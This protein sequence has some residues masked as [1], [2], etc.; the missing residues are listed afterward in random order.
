MIMRSI[1]LFSYF[2]LMLLM[3]SF[4]AL[5]DAV[6]DD[7]EGLTNQD[8]FLYYWYFYD[9]HKDGGNSTIP[10]VTKDAAGDFIVAPAAGIG[11]TGAGL[12]LPYSLGPIKAG[13][14]SGYNSIG[15]GAML[16]A[17]GKSIDLTAATK[18]TFWLKASAAIGVDFNLVTTDVT[19]YAYWHNV[20]QA[21]TA[22]TQFTVTL[23]STGLGALSQP[24]WGVKATWATSISKV[25]KLQWQL[26]SDNVGTA[27]TGSI[28]LDDIVIAGYTFIPP[29][30]CTAC[31]GNPGSGTGALLSDMETLPYSRNARGYYWFSYCDG[32]GRGVA[33]S[34]FSAIT[35]GATID[36]VDPAK[37]TII[38]GPTWPKGYNG[39]NG[40]DIQFT[41]GKAY[42]KTTGG[43]TIKPFVG[44]G[45]NV[46][47]DLG[48]DLYNAQAD[49]AT[50]IYFDYTLSGSSADMFVRLEVYANLIAVE[51]AVHYI[52]LPSTGAGVWKGATV[53][54]SK[55]VLQDW[56]GVTQVALDAT[57]MKKIQWAV[58]WDAGATG[59]LGIDN[60]HMLGAT[61]ITSDVKYHFSQTRMLNGFTPSISNNM[62]KVAFNKGMSDVSAS[63]VNTKG[64]I[65]AHRVAGNDAIATMNVSGLS[66]GVYMLVV[67][68]NSKTGAFNKTV[69]LTIY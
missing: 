42:T 43:S 54:F 13:T 39:S 33:A 59:E 44:I 5:A 66:R 7:F 18:I 22:W 45:T 8:K 3:A 63:L 20:C 65:V 10:G 51:G 50:G 29:D 40:A 31:V 58:Q 32:A 41:L 34:E 69:P 48:T 49:G 24:T 2:F 4:N 35:G 57:I 9:D 61:K 11:H 55:L 6:V 1:Q 14:G 21:T 28:T 26:H 19:D 52:D 38:I 56:Q 46:A 16:C 23:A 36:A 17:E 27:T 64:A 37:S 60:V 68:A 15:C 67:K 12:T 62:L 25:G 53:P 30:L 47:S